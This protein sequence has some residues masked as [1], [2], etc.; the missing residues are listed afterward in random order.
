MVGGLVVYLQLGGIDRGIEPSFGHGCLP[1]FT[2][3]P[4]GWAKEGV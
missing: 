2:K 3:C 4:E 1:D